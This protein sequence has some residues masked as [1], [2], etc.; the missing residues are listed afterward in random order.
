MRILITGGSGFVGAQL[1]FYLQG[2]GHHI[3]IMDNLVR[4][5]SELNLPLFKQQGIEFVHGDVRS[6]EDFANITGAVDAIVDASAQPSLVYGYANPV[7]D[8]TNNTFGLVN[9]LEFARHRGCPL[10]FCSTNRVYSADRINE[11][12]RREKATRLEWD[13]EAFTAQFGERGI[14]GFDPAHGISEEFSVDGGQHGIYGLS[15]IMA[16]LACQE[17]ADAF[18]VKTVINRFGVL[19]GQGQ[20]GKSEQGWT[21]WWAIAFHFGLPLRLI[22][23]GGKQVRDVL[24]IDDV[25]RLVELEIAQADRLSGQVFNIGGGPGQTISLLEA[26]NLMRKK[27]GRDV[28]VTVEPSPRKADLG[29]YVSDTRK[30]QRVLGWSPRVGIEEGFD[31]IIAWVRENEDSLR[32]LYCD[33]SQAVS[34]R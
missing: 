31:K 16:D 15:K 26:T 9:A 33:A 6:R 23:W 4:R 21:A 14:V 19:A 34:A 29:I 20:F 7:F 28:P 10:I 1:A 2:R 32:S 30:V 24:F 17:Y 27:F 5:G 18:G 8:L 22:G 3:T 13:A 11:L 25:C 12:P